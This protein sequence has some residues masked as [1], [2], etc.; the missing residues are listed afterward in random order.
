MV[1]SSTYRGRRLWR[2]AVSLEIRGIGRLGLTRG[3][4]RHHGYKV[5]HS[6]AGATTI[7]DAVTFAQ[8]ATPL[9][10]DSPTMKL[11]GFLDWAEIA[12]KLKGLYKSE[13]THGGGPEPYEPLAMSKLRPL[14][15]WPNFGR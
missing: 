1:L 12:H 9:V 10:Q 14:Y 7:G 6:C 4:S 11:L 5:F 8:G 13:A 3:F 2:R 15:D